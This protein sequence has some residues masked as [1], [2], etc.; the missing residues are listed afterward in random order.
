MYPADFATK[1]STP[2]HDVWGNLPE[3]RTSTSTFL[4]SPTPSTVLYLPKECCRDTLCDQ[5]HRSPFKSV[6]DNFG[7]FGDRSG[8]THS[9]LKST[10]RRVLQRA[11]A[12]LQKG[13]HGEVKNTHKYVRTSDVLGNLPATRSTTKQEFHYT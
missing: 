11:G 1:K 4:N 10:T 6:K 13:G 2:S 12:I 7:V 8:V 3:R 9:A 5:P